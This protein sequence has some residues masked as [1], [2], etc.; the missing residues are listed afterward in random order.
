MTAST[1]LRE[2]VEAAARQ[3]AEAGVPSP[4]HDAEMLAAHAL[5]IDRPEL[6]VRLA[7]HDASQE[8]ADSYSELVAR[9]AKREPLQHITGTAHFRQL[10]LSVGPGVFIPRP[11]TELTAGAAIDAARAIVDSGGVPVVVDMYAG[12]GAIAISA[13]HEVR[14]CVVHAVESDDDAIAWLRRNA[15]GASVVVHRDDVGGV[16][17]RSMSMLLGTVDVVVANPPYVPVGAG[18][19]D[20]EVAEHDPPVALWAGDDG[21]DALRVLES[22]AAR[23]L[24]PGGVVVAEHGD[25]QG[26][27]AVELFTD[28]GRWA[29]IADHLDLNG[30]PRYVTARLAWAAGDGG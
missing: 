7:R 22:A 1:S 2:R 25:T 10:T 24:R 8:A 11:E 3:L 15:Y 26:E 14:P 27:P 18:I 30:R 19:R 12:S 17:D 23:L 5:G 4:R 6:A 20:P 29:D 21:L 28:T 16:C 9:R 13:A